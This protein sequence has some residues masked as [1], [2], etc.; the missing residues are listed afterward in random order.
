MHFAQL[1]GRQGRAEIPVVL[2]NDRMID[3]ALVRTASGLRRLLERPRRFEIK[4][5]GPSVR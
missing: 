1:L 5:A 4:P 2:A 3:S